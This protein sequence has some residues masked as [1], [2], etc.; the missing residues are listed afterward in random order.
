MQV[1]KAWGAREA[2]QGLR[3]GVVWGFGFEGE[4]GFG[5]EVEEGGAA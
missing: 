2:G 1:L 4:V 3:G 5:K